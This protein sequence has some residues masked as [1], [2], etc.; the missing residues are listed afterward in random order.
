MAIWVPAPFTLNCLHNQLGSVGRLV[1]ESAVRW[2]Q[3]QGRV[4]G[5]CKL[6]SAA[7]PC[8]LASCLRLAVLC[9]VGRL[10]GVLQLSALQLWALCL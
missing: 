5:T 7:W 1:G 8:L 3:Q 10:F 9:C 4:Y 6:H 2:W